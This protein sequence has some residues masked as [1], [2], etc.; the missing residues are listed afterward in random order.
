MSR[1][2]VFGFKGRSVWSESILEFLH[3]FKDG[4]DLLQRLDVPGISP[5]GPMMLYLPRPSVNGASVRQ[6]EMLIKASRYRFMRLSLG[7]SIPLQDPGIVPPSI[8]ESPQAL[9]RAGKAKEA[10][11]VVWT[12]GPASTA[13]S[14]SG[15]ES[16]S[17]SV[18][19]PPSR[20][21]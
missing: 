9:Q 2:D 15:L 20:H 6:I 18:Q 1:G 14:Q 4:I 16:S 17:W 11:A 13:P 19:A 12:A 3:Q 10:L 7:R 8:Y 21:M 5:D